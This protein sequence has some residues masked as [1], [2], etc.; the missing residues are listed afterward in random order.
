ME[1][2]ISDI[3]NILNNTTITNWRKLLWVTT[4]TRKFLENFTRMNMN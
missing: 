1:S 4:K 3:S 2:D